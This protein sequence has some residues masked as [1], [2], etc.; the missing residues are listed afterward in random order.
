M[1]DSTPSAGKTELRKFVLNHSS[2]NEHV[3]I[4]DGSNESV[5]L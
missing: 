3:D 5:I 1:R 4:R 2:G